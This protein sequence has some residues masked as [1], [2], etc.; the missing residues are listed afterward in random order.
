ML[1]SDAEL[2]A[3]WEHAVHQSWV[4]RALTLVC[5]FDSAS[6]RDELSRMSIGARD[7]R[8]LSIRAAMFGS[9]VEC[10]TSC[11]G[12]GERVEATFSIDDV[13]ARF[14]GD[15]RVTEGV[16]TV[17]LDGYQV[18]FRLPNSMD[19]LALD[20][21]RDDLSLERQLLA[22]CVLETREQSAVIAADAVPD[23]I[24]VAVAE[25]LGDADP[26]GDVQL[27]LECA[28]CA[29]TWHATFDIVTHLWAE[30]EARAR[31]LLSEVHLLASTYGW[32][33]RDVLAMSS[34]RRHAYLELVAT[35]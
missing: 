1:P 29:H 6:D 33:E 17:E 3:A 15:G 32:R 27:A 11:P 20:E 26:L 18:T 8:L 23:S 14:G 16:H 30:I 10:L 22:A 2:L 24:V 5:A 21:R 7:A 12:C 28:V 35:G 13:R 9:N 25:R 34:A 19:L 4:Q 31:R